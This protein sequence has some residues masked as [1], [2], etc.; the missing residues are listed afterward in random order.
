MQG[1]FPLVL[2]LDANGKV[3]GKTGYK[4]VKPAEYISLL[5]SFIDQ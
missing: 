1:Y 5:N 2:L 4:K 3:L